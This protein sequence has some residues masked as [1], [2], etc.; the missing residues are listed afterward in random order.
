[1]VI[2]TFLG[3]AENPAHTKWNK[4]GTNFKGKYV[5]GPEILKMVVNSPMD[6]MS[7]LNS[8]DEE[9][10]WTALAEFFPSPA[11]QG[12]TVKPASNSE[13]IKSL[14]TDPEEI[15][16]LPSSDKIVSIR[17]IK[18]GFE[19]KSKPD[20]VGTF[21]DR[22]KILAAYHIRTG[23]PFRKYHP[24]DFDF[25]DENQI[26]IETQ[27]VEILEKQDNL[28]HVRVLKSDYM[29]K[30]TGFDFRRDVRVEV[31]PIEDSGDEKNL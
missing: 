18:Q 30:I 1:S 9:G 20:S 23:N 21:P 24:A 29:I 11:P 26:N 3:D 5:K 13:E 12:I 16:D 8:E 14:K 17:C 7:V 15:P 2:A 31:K 28:L 27:G 10:D 4:K 25:S 19:I 6:L 22:L